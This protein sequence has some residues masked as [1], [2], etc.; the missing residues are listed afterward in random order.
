MI[1]PSGDTLAYREPS[2]HL[3][4]LGR[5]NAFGTAQWLAADGDDGA[6]PTFSADT[7]RCDP[8]AC[9]A[10]VLDG[11]TLSLVLK[12]EAFEE[13]CARADLIVTPLY[14]P[15]SC[16][17]EMIIDRG[18]LAETGAVTVSVRDGAFV[19]Q[20]TRSTGEDRPWSPAP[21]PV[22]GR[23]RTSEDAGSDDDP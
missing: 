22:H 16:G 8:L 11:R 10:R 14:A 21:A 19:L 18:S 1:A 3:V 7:S 13:D 20:P 5:T 9:V 12:P 15:A 23:I 6:V 4:T 17:A 2:G